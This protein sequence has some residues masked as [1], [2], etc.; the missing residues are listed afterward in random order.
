MS[1]GKMLGDVK[2]KLQSLN[3][4]SDI[5]PPFEGQKSGK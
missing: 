4:S 3:I 5:F 1:E 2:R